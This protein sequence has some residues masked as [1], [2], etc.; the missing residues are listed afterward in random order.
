MYVKG[1][2]MTKFGMQLTSTNA[3]A[4]EAAMEA[5]NDADMSIDDIQAI[6][7]SNVDT[8]INGESQRHYGSVL[9]SILKKK[10]PIIRVPAVCGG[11]GA[12]LWTALRLKYDNIMVLSSDKIAANTTP[13]ITEEILQAAEKV[14]EQDEGMI[15]PAANALVAQQYMA[16]Y[17]A[18]TD[19]LALVALKNHEHAFLNPK[20]RFYKKKV[21]LEKIKAS[22]I[23]ASPLRLYDCSV[24]VNGAA[25]II[26]SNEKTDVKIAG[27]GL[28]TDYLAAFDRDDM[29]TW[30]ATK[31]AAAQAYK[32]ANCTPQDIDVA[33]V[34]DAFTIVELIAYEDLGF[35]KKGEGA[36]L[37]RDGTTK[38]GGKLPVNTS[39]GLKAKGHPISPTGVS[40]AVEIVNQLRNK[41][42]ERQVANAKRGLT[43]NIG[44]AGGTIS[45]HIF[46]KV[47]A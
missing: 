14:W 9:A 4:Y 34:H 23:V 46:E 38:I 6:V 39:G 18:T 11:G 31:E 45:V 40:Q 17:D 30:N 3:M 36:T 2:G 21:T 20:A 27:S 16:K 7:V 33:E 10:V 26:L 15:F 47:A 35:A 12:A 29:T 28:A 22:P 8:A 43:Q 37:I 44:G 25:A 24:S 13:A 1:V 19:D 5:I 42:G 41:C 32:Q